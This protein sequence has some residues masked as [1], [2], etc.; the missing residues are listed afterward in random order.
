MSRMHLRLGFIPLNDAAPLI[1]A[2]EKGFFAAEDLDVELSREAS[3]ANVRDRVAAGL[4]DGGHLLGP[5]PIAATEVFLRVI[6]SPFLLESSSRDRSCRP[7]RSN[8]P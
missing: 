1:V 8:R 6:A 3:W 5:M 7:T 4:I 2:K